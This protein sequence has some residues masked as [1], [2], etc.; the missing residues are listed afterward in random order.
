MKPE[1]FLSD[2]FLKQFKTGEQLNDFLASIQKRAI[3]K[4]LEGELDDT[5]VTTSISRV[6]IPMPAMVMAERK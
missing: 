5:W 2:D 6:I 4:M 3:E 1:D